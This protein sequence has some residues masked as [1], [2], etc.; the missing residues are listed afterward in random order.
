[1]EHAELALNVVAE[2]QQILQLVVVVAQQNLQPVP[3]SYMPSDVRD[4]E[5]T[6]TSL[7]ILNIDKQHENMKEILPTENSVVTLAVAGSVIVA[8]SIPT[9]QVLISD[10]K[11]KA[12]VPIPHIGSSSEA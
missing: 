6:G 5:A 12:D 2:A 4:N 11:G 7:L 10:I 9:H 8:D 1:M 3:T